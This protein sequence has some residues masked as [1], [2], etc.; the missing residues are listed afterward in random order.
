MVD[1]DWA[2][3]T[4]YDDEGELAVARIRYRLHRTMGADGFSTLAGR[5]QLQ[6]EYSPL[7]TGMAQ[8][9]CNQGGNRVVR[10]LRVSRPGGDGELEVVEPQE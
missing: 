1:E 7:H 2:D 6:E 9:A 4:L 10:V 3:G 5:F 8:L